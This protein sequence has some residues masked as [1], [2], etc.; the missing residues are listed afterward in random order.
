MFTLPVSAGSPTDGSL[1][2]PN[3][4][5]WSTPIYGGGGIVLNG[6]AGSILYMEH[7]N[8]PFTNGGATVNGGTL[9]LPTWTAAGSGPL[10]IGSGVPSDAPATIETFSPDA[11]A[12]S[13][14]FDGPFATLHLAM[15]LVPGS[16][17]VG[18][19]DQLDL[20]QVGGG[21]VTIALSADYMNYQF[22][23]VADPL[24]G[25]DIAL[26]ATQFDV[27]SAAQ[28]SQ[29]LEDISVGGMDSATNTQFVV[30][31]D[32]NISGLAADLSAINLGSGDLLEIFGENHTLEANGTARGLFV[33]AGS[34]QIF[35]LT[36]KDA[37][38]AGGTGGAGVAGGGGGAGL[39]GGLFVGQGAD[40]QLQSVN[41][42]SDSAVGGAGGAS[43]GQGYG[44]GGGLGGTGGAGTANPSTGRYAGLPLGYG[45][46][47]GVG[48]TAS[49]AAGFDGAPF[50]YVGSAGAGLLSGASPGG[51]APGIS[52]Y[53][54]SGGAQGGGGAQGA[55]GGAGGFGYKTATPGQGG[56][57]GGGGAGA[58]GGAGGYGGGGGA[59]TT[60]GAGGFG[61]GGGGGA[62]GGAAGGFGAGTGGTAGGGGLGAGGAIFVQ[63][64]GSLEIAG[65]T[66]TGGLASGGA[67]SG[68][69]SDGIGLGA[70]MFLAGGQTLTL[71]ADPSLPITIND[72]ITD[73]SGSGGSGVG[74]ILA[75]GTG[76]VT[77]G[78]I[79][80][81]TGGI[82]LSAS[83]TLELGVAGAEGS[84]D[85]TFDSNAATLRI[86]GAIAPAGTITGFISGDAIDLH[87]IA[88]EAGDTLD[89]AAATGI[90]QILNAGS[91]VAALDFGVGNTQWMIRSTSRRTA[92]PASRSPTT[93][94]ASAAARKSSRLG[95]RSPSRICASAMTS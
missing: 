90:L 64:G 52:P 40:V 21:A 28:L 78:A 3:T 7:P 59:G 65:G 5:Y 13:F 48:N 69:G 45:G 75:T 34:V 83:V 35:N 61:G 47:G 49:G 31:I 44:G 80:S 74:A 15:S 79:N 53:Y 1:F 23:V 2:G 4:V 36:I 25:T 12:N 95:A 88:F 38:A 27:Y 77:L 42:V 43:A 29:A 67:G 19:D 76:S 10:S 57:G 84:G 11:P 54:Y 92:P 72:A 14:Y 94:H 73:G 20:K 22:N 82:T 70:G 85:I 63:Q 56:F 66:E 37:V 16:V 87:D 68:G 50:T 51:R 58:T 18:P 62:S 60:G 9:L 17:T 46:G 39:G 71:L 91:S 24:F 26:A 33:E 81:F 55:G 6:V 8:G 89:Y 93:S 41:F 30:T 86:D 32:S